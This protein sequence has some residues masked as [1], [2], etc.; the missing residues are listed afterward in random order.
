MSPKLWGLQ[1]GDSELDCR[2]IWCFGGK[3][4]RGLDHEGLV[5]EIFNL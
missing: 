5:K 1:I 3:C 2:G 4:C